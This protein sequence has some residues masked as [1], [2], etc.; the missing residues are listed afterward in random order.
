MTRWILLL[1]SW[2]CINADAQLAR[3]SL[4]FTLSRTDFVDSI[5]I[6]WDSHQ[7]Y[8]PVTINGRQHRFL[9]DTGAGQSVIFSDTQ[10]EGCRPAGQ[11]IAYDANNRR[12]TVAVVKLPPLTLGQLTLTGLQATVQQRTTSNQ[13]IDGIIGFDLFCKGLLAKIDV[14]N[15][16]L[17]LTDRKKFFDQEDGFDMR[18]QLHY[19]VPYIQVKPFGR[20]KER[21]L[22]DTGSRSLYIMNKESFDQGEQNNAATLV[23]QIEGRSEGRHA[24]GHF[25]LEKRGEVVFLHFHQLRMGSF[26]FADVH[27][28]TTQG[29]S[30]L[31]AAVLDYGTLIINPR[32]RR[33]RFQSYDGQPFVQVSNPQLEIAFIEKDGLPAVGL[34]WEG[35]TPYQLG[36]REGDII[37][38]ID[39]RPVRSFQQFL[40][41]AFEPGR[42][43]RFTLR[44]A[45]GTQREVHWVR[46]SK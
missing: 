44:D 26:L 35:G 38:Q 29:G 4:D 46:I 42:E 24:M 7:V 3:Y 11:M 5:A 30:H 33:L 25:G 39:N 16:R 31:G 37:T 9:L 36:F 17:I 41:W 14:A 45:L 32:K 22:F 43:Y 13:T 1:A 27:T 6:E 23:S 10:P 15:R 19:H 20:Y 2:L 21:V 28:I 12:D 34:V 8:L 18:Y 40:R